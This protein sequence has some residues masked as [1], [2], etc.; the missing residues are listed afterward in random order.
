MRRYEV[1]WL[2]QDA[3]IQELARMGPAAPL[4]HDAFTAFARGSLV[5]TEEGPVA[6]EDLLPGMMIRTSDGLQPLMW[7]GGISVRPGSDADRVLPSRLY[8][9]TADRF[10]LGRPMPDLVLGPGARIVDRSPGLRAAF[11]TPTALVPIASH[12]DGTSVIEMTPI[13][14]VQMFHLGFRGHRLFTVNGVE[15]ESC[16]PGQIET[17]RH[18]PELLSL[19]LSLFPHVRS[20]SDFGRLALPRLTPD[21]FEELQAA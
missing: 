8:R 15:V 11:G 9:I 4:F 7:K 20:S 17:V 16:H 14:P 1:M 19:F 3:Q 10:G 21:E 18:N 13:A 5:P 2:D 12:S 6:V